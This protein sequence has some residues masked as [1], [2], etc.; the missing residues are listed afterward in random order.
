M[1]H[2]IQLV[3]RFGSGHLSVPGDSLSDFRLL[4]TAYNLPVPS[5]A[6]AQPVMLLFP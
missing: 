3:R 1:D 5:A 2:A 4:H 6:G